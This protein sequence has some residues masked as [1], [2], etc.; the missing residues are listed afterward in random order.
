MKKIFTLISAV[1]LAGMIFSGCGNSLSLDDEGA[2]EK[3]AARAAVPDSART[4]NIKVY[5]FNA[6]SEK[7]WNVWAWR[8]EGANDSNYNA[9]AWPGGDI[10]LSQDEELAALSASFKVDPNY[11]MGILFVSSD[12]KTQTKDISV[13]KECLEDGSSLYFVYGETKCYTKAEDCIGLRSA[14]LADKDCKA[15]S[16]L[17]LGY[18][19]EKVT[20]GTVSVKDKDG[21]ALSV[22]KVAF[23]EATSTAEIMI[24]DG[25]IEKVPYT[26]SFNGVE[27]TAGITSDLLDTLGKTYDGDDLGLTLEGN[28]ATFKVWAPLAEKASLLLYEDVT[29]VGNFK[30]ATVAA[31]SSGSADEPELKGSPAETL[32]MAKDS[33]TGV[34]SISGVDVSK[35]KYYKYQ[36]TNNSGVD[37]YVAD[38]YAKSCSPDSIASQIVDINADSSAIPAGS[39]YGTKESYVNPFGNSGAETKSYSDAVIYEMHIR[40][41]S[42]AVVTDSTGKFIDIANSEKIMDHLKELGVTHVQILPMFDYAQVNSD[43]DYNWGYNPYHYNVPEGRYTD[44]SSNSDGT[45]AVEQMREMIKKFHENGIAVNMDVVYNHTSGTA[46]G[47]LYDS[48]VLEYFYRVSDGS[49]SNG[50]GCGNETA[51]NHKMVK[52]YVVDSLKH[53]MLDYHINGFRF[54]LMGVHEKETMKAIYDELSKIDPNVM[55]YGEP[56]T[57]GTAAVEDSAN[58][59]VASGRMG[60]GAFDDDF[61]DA[62]KGAEFGG[63]QQGQV[64]GT[65]N[66]SGIINGLVGKSGKNKRNTTENSALALHYIECHDNYTLFDK[67]AISY[68]GKT[69]FSGDLFNAI[70]KKG[71]EEVKAQDK[72]AAAYVFLS[73]G[74][75]FLNGGQEFLRTKQGDENSYKSSDSINAIDLGFKEKYSDVFNVYRGLIALRKDFSAFR[76]AENPTAT[77]IADGVT[78]YEVSAS[79]GNFAVIFNATSKNASFDSLTGKIVNV[80]ASLKPTGS[81]L[82][83]GFKD[84]STVAEKYTIADSETTVSSVPAKSFVILKK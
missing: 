44:Y 57:G 43:T 53:W 32:E 68:L 75:P 21:N 48:T 23:D 74:T 38:I 83:L 40:D 52:K 3:S 79:D 71:L 26:V 17:I 70:G 18:K 77:A 29:K 5:V 28:T 47:S 72:L 19:K 54:D 20:E 11:E 51:T 78:L 35:Y 61:R 16:A 27:K 8:E 10:V 9:Q 80:N 58:Q 2:A 55:V 63:F 13:L 65:F 59:A 49:Y 81:Y 36:I 50:S 1:F 62:I 22:G 64:Q 30:A 15:V 7:T 39:S 25:S 4:S 73:Q 60:A 67:L 45:A 6:D 33:G 31:K 76:N 24:S 69:S 37:Y 66:D 84:I 56:W 14:K 41:W 46:G 42:R 12:N 34:W 82:G